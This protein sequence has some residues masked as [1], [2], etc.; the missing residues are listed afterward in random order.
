MNN[1]YFPTGKADGY[2]L[3]HNEG[4]CEFPTENR[5]AAAPPLNPYPSI[6]NTRLGH[7]ST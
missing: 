4:V 2:Y 6:I 7:Y 1:S 5:Q 3:P